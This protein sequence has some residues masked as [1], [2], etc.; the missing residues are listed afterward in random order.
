MTLWKRPSS[1]TLQWFLTGILIAAFGF[2]FYA[3][4]LR[5]QIENRLYD[6]RV[7]LSPQVSASQTVVTLD[8]PQELDTNQQIDAIKYVLEKNPRVLT[9]LV[10]PPYRTSHIRALIDLSR[11]DPRF[12]IGAMDVNKEEWNLKTD[13]DA[14]VASANIEQYYW[15]RIVRSLPF[16]SEKNKRGQIPYLLP[17]M[18]M[19]FSSKFQIE[20][21]LQSHFAYHVGTEHS[22]HFR[23]NYVDPKEVTSWRLSDLESG[24]YVNPILDKA[25]IMGPLK[26]IP[27]SPTFGVSNYVNTPWQEDNGNLENGVPAAKVLAMGLQN[28]IDQRW[29]RPVS[30]FWNF[31]QVTALLSLSF[32]IW[33]LG[34]A[35]AAFLF[36]LIWAVLMLIHA[37]AFALASIYIPLADALFFSIVGTIAGGLHRLNIEGQKQAAHVEQE[38]SSLELTKIQNTY[39]DRLAVDLKVE[40][41]NILKLLEGVK[42]NN[43]NEGQSSVALDKAHESALELD[44]F[45]VGIQQFATMEDAV[46]EHTHHRWI[47]TEDI[48]KRII[49]RFDSI[50]VKKNLLVTISTEDRLHAYSNE[51]LLEQIL[52]NIISN[53]I[54]YSPND[55]KVH[56]VAS[57]ERSKRVTFRVDDEGPG[58]PDDIGELIFEKFFRVKNDQV[59]QVKGHGLGLYL[60]KYF[61]NTIRAKIRFQSQIHRGTSFFLTV[62]GGWQ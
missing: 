54:K 34:S 53:A 19:A 41:T 57:M 26:Y 35:L 3:S 31:L 8:F 48:I 60:S 50:I 28:L 5:E 40:N 24:G 7:I 14:L 13:S 46:K 45:L 38:K 47:P 1:D 52:Y 49:K 23:L 44:E 58:I 17:K 33:R 25:V 2:L 27:K 61:A 4:P 39:L 12:I 36:V 51:V 30:I 16:L 6:L 11:E 56:V 21:L 59:Y 18:A 29:L 32:A 55:G 20:Q 10:T 15:K 42:L 22:L 62:K 37:W 43:K 9:L